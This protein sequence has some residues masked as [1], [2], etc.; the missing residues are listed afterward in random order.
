MNVFAEIFR[1]GKTHPYLDTLHGLNRKKTCPEL[2]RKLSVV[3]DKT[4]QTYR[5]SA[6]DYLKN[7]TDRI[8]GLSRLVHACHHFFGSAGVGA[9]HWG[10]RRFFP[11]LF[12]CKANCVKFDSTDG[13]HVAQ[14]VHAELFKENFVDG[15]EGARRGGFPRACALEDVTD[16]SAAVLHYSDQVRMPRSRTLHDRK[17]VDFKIFV[18]DRQSDRSAERP[19]TAEARKNLRTVFFNRHPPSAAITFLAS[20]KLRVDVFRVHQKSRHHAFQDRH[21]T[22]PVRFSRG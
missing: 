21:E 8:L 10:S 5:H 7:S 2:C 12:E 1:H 15:P 3:M 11:N 18:G 9:V 22:L 19:M 16:V 13:H 6:D 14:E 4:S 20:G 17:L